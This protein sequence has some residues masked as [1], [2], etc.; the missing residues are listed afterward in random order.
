MKYFVKSYVLFHIRIAK[1]TLLG[2]DARV[3]VNVFILFLILL[4]ITQIF[5]AANIW[6]LIENIFFLALILVNAYFWVLAWPE[7]DIYIKRAK[8]LEIMH[9]KYKLEEE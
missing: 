9:T 3:I 8:E 5:F 4:F 1:R 2:I 6:K 7:A